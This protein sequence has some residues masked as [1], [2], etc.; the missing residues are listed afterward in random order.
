MH[1]TCTIAL[2]ETINQLDLGAYVWS[3][4][5]WLCMLVIMWHSMIHDLS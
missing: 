2:G 1:I 5:D 4:R 3:T